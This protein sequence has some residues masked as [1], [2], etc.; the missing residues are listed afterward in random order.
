MKIKHII[1]CSGF[2]LFTIA[3]CSSQQVPKFNSASDT[4]YFSNPYP[5]ILPIMGS[6]A[7]HAGVRLP[8]PMGVMFNS[9]VGRQVR[10]EAQFPGRADSRTVLPQ[11]P[12]RDL[13]EELVF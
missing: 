5:Y 13:G 8:F 9:L 10:A 2:A 7:H 3:I 6:K 1:S 12:L 11:L 4:A